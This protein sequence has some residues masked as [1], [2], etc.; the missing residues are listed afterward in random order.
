MSCNFCM[1]AYIMSWF[2]FRTRD[3]T[4]FCIMAS[5]TDDSSNELSEVRMG[6]MIVYMFVLQLIVSV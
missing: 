5:L 3:D 1:S 6:N 2:Y 4:V